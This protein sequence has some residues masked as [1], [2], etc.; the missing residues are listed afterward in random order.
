MPDSGKGL[1]G[2]FWTSIR[3]TDS[4]V[5]CSSVSKRSFIILR[6]LESQSCEW[7]NKAG[8][9]QVNCRRTRS[10]KVL[11]VGRRFDSAVCTSELPSLKAC[12]KENA[13]VR[14]YKLVKVKGIV[15]NLAYAS[16]FSVGS[17]GQGPSE[18]NNVTIVYFLRSTSD[19]A[20]STFS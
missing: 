7:S 6:S 12:S 1:S 15:D 10:G 18:L 9:V 8:T 13:L 5:F 4:S 2:K 19:S 17:F 14:K 20:S 3:T 16:G 11:R